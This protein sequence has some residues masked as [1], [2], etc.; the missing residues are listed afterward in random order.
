MKAETLE[1]R[2]IAWLTSEGLHVGGAPLAR[3]TSLLDFVRK[4]RDAAANEVA[5]EKGDWLRGYD[6]AV[7]EVLDEVKE[8]DPAL[9]SR[10]LAKYP[11]W[12][13]ALCNRKPRT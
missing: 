1:S 9:V 6:Q 11:V 10:I 2:V 8:T 3:G 12:A 7:Q 13:D 4:E 5:R